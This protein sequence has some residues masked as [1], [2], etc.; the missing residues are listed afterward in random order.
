MIIGTDVLHRQHADK[1][2][3][4]ALEAAIRELVRSGA[5]HD[6]LLAQ[7][8]REYAD[9]LEALHAWTEERW[10]AYD[11]EFHR[12]PPEVRDF[13]PVDLETVEGWSVT[14]DRIAKLGFRRTLAHSDQSNAHL[15]LRQL[16]VVL[17]HPVALDS[18]YF[19]LYSNHEPPP[20]WSRAS[21]QPDNDFSV[22]AHHGTSNHRHSIRSVWQRVR[23]WV[24]PLRR[25]SR[26]GHRRS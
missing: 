16:L 18:L 15:S 20:A 5:D 3:A 14:V 6:H 13:L 24:R 17:Y 9:D 21:A 10:A 1:D 22:R 25:D 26:D 11:E 12:D 4:M 23:D 7:I 8:D 19:R 2:L